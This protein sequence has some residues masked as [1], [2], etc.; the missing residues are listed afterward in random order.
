[1]RPSD[2]A[3]KRVLVD[4]K[5]NVINARDAKA[6]ERYFAV[7]YR[8][9]VPGRAPGLA[10]LQAALV[11]F[12]AAFPDVE[13]SIDVLLAEGDLVASRGTIRATHRGPFLGVPATGKRVTFGIQ[14][15]S[16]IA[17][18]VVVEQWVSFDVAGLLAQLRD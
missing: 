14:E 6:A 15:I 1:M 9:D 3:A 4:L 17:N 7:D 2:D 11:E 5:R 13:E 16:R 18:G 10:G 12:F 8:N